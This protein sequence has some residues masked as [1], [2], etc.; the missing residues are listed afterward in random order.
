MQVNDRIKKIR[1]LFCNDSNLEFAERLGVKSQFASNICNSK[2]VGNN[3]FDNILEKFPE[4]SPA[5]L[6]MGIEPMLSNQSN[7]VNEPEIQYACRDC[8]KKDIK[9][10]LLETEVKE[11]TKKYIGLLEEIK[12]KKVS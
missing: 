6:K 10:E 4:I 8:K 5:W 2:K 9:I 12:D 1:E 11:L 3:V 7:A